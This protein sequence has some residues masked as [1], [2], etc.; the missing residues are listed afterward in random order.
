MPNLEPPDSSDY[1]EDK[2]NNMQIFAF[3]RNQEQPKEKDEGFRE[4]K[5][6]DASE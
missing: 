1:I 6:S 5:R 3:K 2:R 4:E